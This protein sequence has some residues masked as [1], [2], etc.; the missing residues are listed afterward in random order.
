MTRATRLSLSMA[1]SPRSS[2]PAQERELREREIGTRTLGWLFVAGA[3]IGLLTLALPHSRALDELGIVGIATGAYAMAALLL[4][5]G[6][7]GAVSMQLAVLAGTGLI[8]LAVGFSDNPGGTYAFYYLWVTVYAAYFLTRVEAVVQ[9]GFVALAYGAA[10]MMWGAGA[11]RVTTWVVAIGSLAVAAVV[12]RM[13]KERLDELVRQLSRAAETDPLTGLLNRRGF[14]DR[15]AAELERGRR[16][17]RPVGILVGDLDHFKSVNDRFGHA[18]GDDALVRVAALLYET[19]RVSDSVARIGGEEF[20]MILPYTGRPGT[21]ILAERLRVSVRE[22]FAEDDVALTMSFGMAVFPDDGDGVEALLRAADRA[23]Y[24]AK[25][26]GRDRSV[27]AEELSA[28]AAMGA[29][30]TNLSVLPGGRAKRP[31]RG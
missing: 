26:L 27:G 2:A 24:A 13:L 9:L 15:L 17:G 1:P 11:T 14:N 18:A 12:V 19:R 23:M 6:P 3:T 25:E 20:A 31:D 8:T 4:L 28:T 21:K 5:T 7:L 22:S 30:A 29:P 10:L 16:A